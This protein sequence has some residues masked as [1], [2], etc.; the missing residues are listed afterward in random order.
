MPSSSALFEDRTQADLEAEMFAD[1][2]VTQEDL[3]GR[4]ENTMDPAERHRLVTQLG[5]IARALGEQ[6]ELVEDA[7]IDEWERD[8]AE[9]R[10]PD[11][12]KGL[13]QKH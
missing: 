2:Y 8:L 6:E 7:L 13:K 1:L 5:A 3:Q 9:G 4:L 10:T 12:E 11:L